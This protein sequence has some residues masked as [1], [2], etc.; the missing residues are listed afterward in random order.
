MF[1]V[2]RLGRRD[3]RRRIRRQGFGGARRLAVIHTAHIFHG[4]RAAAAPVRID[5]NLR[6]GTGGDRPLNA[7]A[8]A[9]HDRAMRQIGRG[10][11]GS[12]LLGAGNQKAGRKYGRDENR[13][14]SHKESIK[15]A[16]VTSRD[17]NDPRRAGISF[18]DVTLGGLS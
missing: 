2:R 10:G 17:A 5:R 9:Q 7:R 3:R 15:Q 18:G 12:I 1:F 4:N 14:S 6:G 13:I 8:V 16:L 11:R